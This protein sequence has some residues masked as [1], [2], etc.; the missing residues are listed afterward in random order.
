VKVGE[1]TPT[2][3]GPLET[4]NVNHTSRRWKK[5]K[6][7]VILCVIHHRQNQ[8]E[9][10][11]YLDPDYLTSGLERVYCNFMHFVGCEIAESLSKSPSTKVLLSEEAE[12]LDMWDYDKILT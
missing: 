7:S 1:K 5:S 11:S 10:F 9:Y 8:L 4:A 12:G 2:Q 3:L 6:N